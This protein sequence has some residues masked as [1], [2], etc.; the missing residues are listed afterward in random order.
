MRRQ[1]AATLAIFLTTAC[2][3]PTDQSRTQDEASSVL[4]SGPEAQI[5][6]VAA[7]DLPAGVRDAVL[8]RVPGMT[9]T[10]AK[11][12]QRDGMIFYDVEGTRPDGSEV[13][14]DLLEEK[15]RFTV[16]EVQRDIP[17]AEAP[18]PVIAAARAA[19]DAFEP[20]RVIE[21]KQE[22]GTVIYELFAA[23]KSD[24]PAAEIDWKDGKAAVRRERAIY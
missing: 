6:A 21:S 24:E 23:G 2:G 22:D 13:E 8:G 10:G 19:P 20:V 17:W 1:L 15:G 12:K 11:R 14:L 18:A 5:D 4:P 9:I 3:T 16:V 7:A